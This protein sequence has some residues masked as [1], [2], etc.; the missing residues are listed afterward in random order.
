MTP[1]DT[2]LQIQRTEWR[3]RLAMVIWRTRQPFVLSFVVLGQDLGRMER[4]RSVT[5]PRY[6]AARPTPP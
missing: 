1:N 6:R 3:A 4:S 5:C 2:L